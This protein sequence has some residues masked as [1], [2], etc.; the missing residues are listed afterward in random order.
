MSFIKK[1]EGSRFYWYYWRDENGKQQGK[2]LET[3]LRDIAEVKKGEEDKK[4]HYGEAGLPFTKALWGTA[5]GSFLAGYKEGATKVS[6]ERSFVLFEK[7]ASPIRPSDIDYKKAK[8]FRDWMIAR[9]SRFGRVYRPTTVNI[10]IQNLHTFFNECKRL[11]YVTDNPFGDLK[12][13]PDTRRSHKYFTKQQIQSIIKEAKSSWPPDRLLMLFFF[14]YT[15]VR[16]GELVNLRWASIDLEKNLFYLHGSETWEPKDRE[17]HS[18]GLH[19]DLLDHLRRHPRGSEYVFPGME[20]GR[21]CKFSVERLFNRLYRRAGI[22]SVTGVHILRHSF[23][24]HSGL[25]LKAL[26]MVLGHSDI[27]TTMRYSHVTPEDVQSVT[28]ISYF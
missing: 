25:N 19:P 23:A 10:Q 8:G 17:E 27:S 15:G 24:T 26:Q 28:K 9:K 5:K 22:D 1:R 16:L 13:V 21:R 4:R 14:L 20:G 3:E 2:S 12:H 7:Y 6:H 11:K 18:I